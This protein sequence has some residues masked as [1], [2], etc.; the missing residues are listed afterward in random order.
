MAWCEIHTVKS[1]PFNHIENDN[2][3]MSKE[4]YNVLITAL[5]MG[6]I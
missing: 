1:C 2:K 3:K 4:N 6:R 5:G